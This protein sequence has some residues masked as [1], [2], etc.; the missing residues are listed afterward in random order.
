MFERSSFSFLL[1]RFTRDSRGS[2]AIILA[3][4][5]VPLTMC[6][7]MAVDVTNAYRVRTNLQAALDAAML[8]AATA[9]GQ[10]SSSATATVT[11]YVTQN[12]TAVRGLQ[13][14]AIS[15]TLSGTKMSGTATVDVPTNFIKLVRSEPIPITATSKVEFGAGDLEVALALDTTASMAGQKL[16]DLKLAAKDLIDI[17]ITRAPATA[18]VPP[19]VGIVPFGSYVNVG[20][21]YRSQPWMSVP[22]D[23]TS[24]Y[25]TTSMTGQT[26]TPNPATT[27]YADGVPYSCSTSTCTGGTP[28]TS[29]VTYTTTWEG[30]VGSRDTPADVDL[31][32]AF[33]YTSPDQ[34]VPGIMGSGY[35]GSPLTR[36]SSS[37]GTLNTQIDS[38]VASGDT[39]IPDGLLWAW[40]LV[41][42]SLPF[43]DG[44]SPTISKDVRKVV[45]L[46]T[47]GFNTLEQSGMYHIINGSGATSG[48][49]TDARTV[50]LCNSIKAQNVT[51]FTVAF[52]VTDTRATTL[53]QQCASGPPFYFSAAS[54][55]DLRAAFGSIGASMISARL[56][57]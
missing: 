30:C 49:A 2:A 15:V 7:G 37:A 57:Q 46:M 56:V 35:C 50:Q 24:S 51:I 53:M 20:T 44:K 27:C 5:T 21:A 22:A 52:G 14:P 34:P 55:A 28:V 23:S 1:S 11:T 4:A 25:T 18:P 31:Q 54:G 48:Q 42:P 33:A 38:L 36:L 39:Y 13:P 26:C 12:F 40:R 17:L 43:S 10:N 9:A 8:S 32:T 45:V 3:L 41:A 19:R 29:T 16:D 6:A 47:D